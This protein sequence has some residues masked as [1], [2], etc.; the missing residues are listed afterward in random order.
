MVPVPERV[1]LSVK[2]ATF[3]LPPTVGLLP[4]GRV[5]SLLTVMLPP[6]WLKFTALK[7]ALLQERVIDE[8][9]SNVRVPELWVK[10]PLVMVKLP[11]T[12]MVPDVEVNVPAER[13]NLSLISIAESPPVKVPA[14]W[15]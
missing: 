5:Q 10:V 1:P 2:S 11:D 12:V 13:V 7:V 6:V 15:I 8:N 9:P 14:A 3:V 4:K